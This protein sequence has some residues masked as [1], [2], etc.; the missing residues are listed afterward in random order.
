MSLGIA[1]RM[2]QVCRKL[3]HGLIAAVGALFTTFE[4]DLLYTEGQIRND[5]PRRGEGILDVLEGDGD[6]RLPVIGHLA[7]Q[8]F[9]ERH[10]Q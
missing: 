10:A 7:C 8:H 2:A 4:H 5:L 9:I 6:C 3:I 1:Q